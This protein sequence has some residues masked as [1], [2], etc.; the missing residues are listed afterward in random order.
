MAAAS[1]YS[2]NFHVLLHHPKTDLWHFPFCFF[3]LQ[4]RNGPLLAW[5][6]WLI[7]VSHWI[8]A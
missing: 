6:W 4:F 8:G 5:C 1:R 3:V 7:V 2:T